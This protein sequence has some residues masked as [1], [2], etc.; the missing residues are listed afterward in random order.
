MRGKIFIIL[1]IVLFL[2][3]GFLIIHSNNLQNKIIDLEVKTEKDKINS[4][5]RVDSLNSILEDTI[6][7]EIDFKIYNIITK[8][9]I[10]KGKIITYDKKISI[11][12]A[13]GGKLPKF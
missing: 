5:I 4:I 11:I 10:V 6:R 7:K 13:S 1:F 2:V 8:D 12:D 3:I 9:S